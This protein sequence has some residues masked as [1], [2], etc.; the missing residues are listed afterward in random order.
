M[1]TPLIFGR[2]WGKALVKLCICAAGP[3]NARL[4]FRCNYANIHGTFVNPI[5]LCPRLCSTLIIVKSKLDYGQKE[6]RET[7]SVAVKKRR[8]CLFRLKIHI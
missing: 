6:Q 8:K 5:S 3:Q 2:T 7:Q 1:P 4:T